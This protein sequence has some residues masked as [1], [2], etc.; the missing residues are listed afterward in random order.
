MVYE[1]RCGMGA[2]WCTKTAVTMVYKNHRRVGARWCVKTTSEQWRY[3]AQSR[4][5][6]QEAPVLENYR[7]EVACRPSFTTYL[8]QQDQASRWVGTVP[9]AIHSQIIIGCLMLAV[10]EHYTVDNTYRLLGM[11]AGIW[12][13]WRR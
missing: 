1:N 6:H 11:G 5:T 7:W 12:M 2:R 10:L 8:Q 13:R 9:I 4:Q 3:G